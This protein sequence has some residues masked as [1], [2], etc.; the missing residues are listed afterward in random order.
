MFD[1]LLVFGIAVLF[2]G[3]VVLVALLFC[4]DRRDSKLA[5]WRHRMAHRLNW[6]HAEIETWH[7]DGVVYAGY[8]CATCH[9]VD[10][11]REVPEA[12]PEYLR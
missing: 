4:A 10:D 5:R 7:I 11:V 9:R 2:V 6:H 3:N 8:V 12:L 1:I